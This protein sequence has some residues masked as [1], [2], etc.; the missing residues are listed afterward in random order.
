MQSEISRDIQANY[1]GI[2]S[3]NTK[4]LSMYQR[5]LLNPPEHLPVKIPGTW[6]RRSIIIHRFTSLTL[7]TN[8]N[9]HLCLLLQ[10]DHIVD[11]GATT[12]SSIYTTAAST[13]D[14]STAAT[15]ATVRYWDNRPMYN[16]TAGTAKSC[17]LVSCSVRAYSLASGLNR[18]GTIY[19]ALLHTIPPDPFTYGA[20][21]GTTMPTIP[22]IQNS[23][24][25]RA[26][27]SNGEAIIVCKLPS[28]DDDLQFV[29]PNT[30]AVTRHPNGD[31]AYVM[32]VIA[33]G[34]QASSAIRFEV[35]V[36]F[37]VIPTPES[38]LAGLE[39]PAPSTNSIP[40]L[41]IGHLKSYHQRDL[42]RI[43]PAYDNGMVIEPERVR[44]QIKTT[45]ASAANKIKEAVDIVNTIGS[46][47]TNKQPYK[48]PKGPSVVNLP[49]KLYIPEQR[50][51]DKV[52]ATL[53]S[54]KGKIG[55]FS[56]SN[57]LDGSIRRRN[58]AKKSKK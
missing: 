28:D 54:G 29:A 13:Y 18:T 36:N 19:G 17:R 35:D 38:T 21:A 6:G 43:G 40:A 50:I 53:S 46:R 48:A 23:I 3:T 42:V 12:S 39:T 14:P 16:L 1:K 58:L 22:T 30:S 47:N 32:V 5:S 4:R 57:A 2:L 49:S 26:N 20:D 27:V 9:G 7:T 25:Q 24:M 52:L 56:L 41:E 15:T 31:D 33:Q 51:V 37:E 10:P 34:M 55:G 45:V 11:S 44:K 8:A